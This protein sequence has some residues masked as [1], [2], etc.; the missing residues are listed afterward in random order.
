MERNLATELLSI[1]QSNM[2]DE[3]IRQALEQYHD[4]DIA[5]VF[6]DLE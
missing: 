2:S 4:N 5:N 3:E 1:I 6:E